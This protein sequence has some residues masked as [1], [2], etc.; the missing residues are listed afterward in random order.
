MTALKPGDWLAIGNGQRAMIHSIAKGG[1]SYVIKIP[2]GTSPTGAT[3]KAFTFGEQPKEP[4]L[5][6]LSL[7]DEWQ[8]IAELL[9]PAKG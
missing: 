5:L 6:K 1:K 4:E 7:E 9:Y 8:R 3:F 2:D